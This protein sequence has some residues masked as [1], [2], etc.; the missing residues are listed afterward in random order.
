[1]KKIVVLMILALTISCGVNMS[2][3]AHSKPTTGT[4]E[5]IVE[6]ELKIPTVE[7]LAE[8]CP[9]ATEPTMASAFNRQYMIIQFDDCFEN[10]R[11]LLVLFGPELNDDEITLATA[12]ATFFKVEELE[13]EEE[14]ESEYLGVSTSVQEHP[15]HGQ[16]I[17][18][19]MAFFKLTPKIKL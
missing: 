15:M 2:C 11:M 10:K 14:L 18:V 17:T 6:Q 8:N 12:V 9:P 13:L 7:Y 16:A 19:H 1:M 3:R 4:E 5:I